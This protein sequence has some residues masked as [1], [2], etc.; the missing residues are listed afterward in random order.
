[1]KKLICIMILLLCI[2]SVYARQYDEYCQYGEYVEYHSGE[3]YSFKQYEWPGL[4]GG[5]GFYA[6]AEDI[7]I[8]KKYSKISFIFQ[9][10][11]TVNFV[12]CCIFFDLFNKKNVR[13]ARKRIDLGTVFREER[14]KVQTG[15]KLTKKEIQETERWDMKLYFLY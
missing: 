7:E 8:S 4:G 6:Y 12:D 14:V 2:S 9:H 13:I 3:P 5:G 1:M 10:T 15:L 11:T